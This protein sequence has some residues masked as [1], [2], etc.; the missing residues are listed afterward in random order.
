[1]SDT[2]RLDAETS[3]YAS[4]SDLEQSRTPEAAVNQNTPEPVDERRL[5]S[6]R[7]SLLIWLLL[8]YSTGPVSSM[9]RTYVP[10]AIQSAAHALGHQKGTTKPCLPKGG[11]CVVRFGGGEVDY[12]SYVLYI[13]A[14]FTAVE[15]VIAVILSGIA[16]FSNNKKVFLIIS[17]LL[18]GAAALPFAGLTAKTYPTLMGL[19]ALYGIMNAVSPVYEI[20][21][22]AYIPMFMRARAPAKGAVAEDVRRKQVLA[23]GS[24]VSV[25]GL[26]IG[27]IGGITALLIGIIITYGRGSAAQ[28][29][30]H[31]FL[32]AITIAGCITIAFATVSFF[33]LPSTRGRPIPPGTNLV[34]LPFTRLYDLIKGI[35]RYPEAYKLCVGWVIWNV[36]YTNFLSIFGL[37]FRFELGLGNS[38]KEYTI[39][40]F[41]T[42]FVACIGSLSW[43]YLYPRLTLHIKTWAYGFLFLSIFTIFWGCLGIGEHI[44]VGFKHRAE[45][46]VFEVVYVSSSSAMRSLNRALYS[47]L[48]PEGSEAQYFGLEIVLGVATGWIGTLVNATIQNRTGNLRYPMLPN[49]FLACIALGFYIW[50]DTDKGMRDAEKLVDEDGTS[51]VEEIQTY[52][53]T[54]T[55]KR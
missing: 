24:S 15:G 39:Y 19:S 53:A 32:L 8:C 20:M 47:S 44:N 1:M 48:L 22:G 9:S 16:D 54:T 30:Y 21:E 18:F 26:V 5:W 10:A 40:S 51:E 2:K 55:T 38:D 12:N 17:I 37:L 11:T 52:D 31:N 36:A 13:R 49:V 33:I 42:P 45:F 28:D 23:R 4:N 27:N 7:K 46:W 43:M 6:T 25:L 3:I 35:R 50:V 14:I 29:G 34:T 41:M